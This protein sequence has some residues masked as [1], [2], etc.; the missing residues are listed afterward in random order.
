MADQANVPPVAEASNVLPDKLSV[1]DTPPTS[2]VNNKSDTGSESDAPTYFKSRLESL[3]YWENPKK[4]GITLVS[5]LAILVLTQYYSVLQIVAGAFTIVTGINWAFVN[6][7][8][9]GQRFIGGKAQNALVNPHSKRLESKNGRIPRDRI[10]RTFQHTVD[11]VEDL[12]QQVAKLI[13]IEDNWRSGI[14]V[15]VSYFT[16]TLA[17][18]IPTKY[19][20]GFFIV[21]AFSLPRLYRQHQAVIDAH[22]AQQT[23]N[24]RIITEKYGGVAYQ[25]VQEVTQQV[26][27]TVLKKTSGGIP[28]QKKTE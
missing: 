27:D 13:L 21:S 9:Q 3:I 16:W 8:K 18:Y 15:I 5:L 1:P 17:K 26:K 4:S 12:T 22:V 25:K 28:P 10:L 11:V 7:H 2:S 19:L 23:Q 20:V 14:A 6:T 24:A